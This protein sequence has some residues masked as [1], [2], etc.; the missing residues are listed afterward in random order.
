M[1]DIPLHPKFQ[2]NGSSYT[3]E[4][5]SEH[6]YTL[7]KEGEPY[8]MDIGAFLL[9]WLSKEPTLTVRTSGSTGTPKPIVIKKIHMVNSAMA[10]GSFFKLEAGNTALHCLP[11]D[12][13]AGKMMLVRAMVLG[14]RLTCVAPT[15]VRIDTKQNHYDFAAMVPLQLRNSMDYIDCIGS[16]I[17]GGAPFSPDLKDLVAQKRTKI[18]ET[19]GMTETVTHIAIKQVNHLNDRDLDTSDVFNVVP[20]VSLSQ[21][22]RDCLIIH[23]PKVADSLIV[24][25]DVV[26]LVSPTQ[27]KWLGRYD[28]VIN[29]GGIKLIPEQIEA[30]LSNIISQRFFITGLTDEVLGQKLVLVVEGKIQVEEIR[31]L[32]KSIEELSK[33]QIPKN[34]FVLPKFL[35]TKTGKI[36]RSKTLELLNL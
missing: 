1:T 28:N 7:V 33:Y 18:Y 22:D 23:A 20:D 5:L 14:L 34:I 6:A 15:S 35:E 10:T 31:Q 30:M 11:T 9:D 27:F 12:F 21:D 25:N 13:I 2:L 19:Y 8:E 29:S 17:V 3:T 32:L 36:H 16:L 24:T 4:E 26:D